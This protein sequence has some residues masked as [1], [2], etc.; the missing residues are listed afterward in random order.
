AMT[1]L[2]SLQD[3]GDRCHL[4]APLLRFAAELL[5]SLLGQDVILCPSVILS[6]FPLA[7]DQSRSLQALEGDEQGAGVDA[8]YALADLFDADRNPVSVHWFQCQRFQNEHI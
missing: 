5:S 3:S 8:E 2:R 1:W 6:G 7:F 4:P